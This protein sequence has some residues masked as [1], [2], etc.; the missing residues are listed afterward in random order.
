MMSRLP[1]NSFLQVDATEKQRNTP[2]EVTQCC[3]G[4]GKLRKELTSASQRWMNASV[5][6]KTFHCSVLR[7]KAFLL[8]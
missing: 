7:S 4:E 3:P 5:E 1:R 2:T 8:T 6:N